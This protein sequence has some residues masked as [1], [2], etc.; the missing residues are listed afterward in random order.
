MAVFEKLSK[1]ICL[2]LISDNRAITWRICRIIAISI[3]P[4]LKKSL[5]WK[6]RLCKLK[7]RKQWDVIRYAQQDDNKDKIT[8]KFWNIICRCLFSWQIRAQSVGLSCLVFSYFF[9][10]K[11]EMSSIRLSN[12]WDHLSTLTGWL[13]LFHQAKGANLSSVALLCWCSF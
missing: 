8:T 13:K 5:D 9:N 7:A 3:A 2:I 10:R 4:Y 6:L 12:G 11:V 1:F